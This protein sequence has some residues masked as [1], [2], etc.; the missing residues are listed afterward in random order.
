MAY[1]IFAI[2]IAIN[3][4][5][6]HFLFQWA[7][8]VIKPIREVNEARDSKYPAFRRY[9]VP[10]WKKFKFYIGAITVLPLR[11]CFGVGILLNLFAIFK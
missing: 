4:I 1:Y 2:L 10:K 5:I 11:F 7:W 6:G 8:K 3:A 9:D